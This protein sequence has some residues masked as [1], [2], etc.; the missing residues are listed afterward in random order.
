MS[1][2]V[3]QNFTALRDVVDSRVVELP[4][5]PQKSRCGSYFIEFA[6]CIKLI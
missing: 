4:L 1:L 5:G 3:I 6:T 2:T